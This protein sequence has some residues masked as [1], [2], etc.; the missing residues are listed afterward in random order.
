MRQEPISGK[1]EIRANNLRVSYGKV[2][3]LEIPEFS[4]KG[5]IIAIIG[6]NGSGKSTML[7]TILKLLVPRSG[8]IETFSIHGDTKTL[9][10]PEKHMAFSPENGAIFEDM[11]VESYIKLWCRIKQHDGD[12]YRGKGSH[13]LE[14]LNVAPLL[15][16]LGRELS[17]G[18][19]RRVQVAVGFL[20][21]PQLFLF[22]EP[23]DGL[24]IVQSNELTNVMLDESRKMSMIVSSH[25][26]EVIER[27]ADIVVVLHE[28]RVYAAGT[29]DEV[30]KTL[31]G[32]SV[33]ISEP[34]NQQIPLEIVL[35]ML[36]KEF[37]SCL[38]NQIGSQL[39]VT[40]NNVSVEALRTFFLKQ[41]LQGIKL[42]PARPSL[43]DAMR[44]YLNKLN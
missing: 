29:V 2:V 9:L 7:K 36:K 10:V 3:A 39:L 16:K 40:G 24:D 1:T 19:R 8:S 28:G 33:L 41:H 13:Y 20:T 21:S 34:Q 42:N 25:R 18:Q 23:F 43:V 5:R 17:K 15:S 31:G 11:P 4:L 38:I 27:L 22:D 35:Q 44:Y 26:M 37:I 30:C 14:R 32:N 6:H 12:Y